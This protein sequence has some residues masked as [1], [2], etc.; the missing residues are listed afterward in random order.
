MYTLF[1]SIDLF[2]ELMTL[3]VIVDVIFRKIMS[4][5]KRRYRL[6]GHTDVKFVSWSKKLFLHVQ[7]LS[8]DENC[9]FLN[10]FNSIS[11]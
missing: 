8:V 6:D 2:S 11:Q 5:N 3:L 7:E 1:P 9:N 10:A 4:N